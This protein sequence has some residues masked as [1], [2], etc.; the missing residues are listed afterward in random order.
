MIRPPLPPNHRRPTRGFLVMDAMVGIAMASALLLAFTGAF[1]YQAQ[2]EKKLAA[3]RASAR[4]AESAL[5]SFQSGGTL[6]PEAR[7]EK[8]TDVAPPPPP[9]YTWVRLTLPAT[10]TPFCQSN[11]R[12]PGRRQHPFPRHTQWRR[13][14]HE[15]AHSILPD[16]AAVPS[17]SSN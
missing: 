14:N 12:R 3:I 1:F 6:P 9:G 17:P 16:A 5:L 4:L 7:I 15:Q 11:P 13:P 10:P 2:A 8:L